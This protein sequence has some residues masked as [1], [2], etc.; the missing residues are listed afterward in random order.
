MSCDI[1]SQNPEDNNQPT[2]HFDYVNGFTYVNTYKWGQHS[3]K[4]YVSNNA[5]Y[6]IDLQMNGRIKIGPLKFNDVV[7]TSQLVILRHYC[8]I[9]RECSRLWYDLYCRIYKSDSVTLSLPLFTRLHDENYRHIISQHTGPIPDYYFINTLSF[10]TR[11]EIWI[12]IDGNMIV[13]ID[14]MC[15]K[16]IDDKIGCKPHIVKFHSE[17]EE[18][19]EMLLLLNKYV[20]SSRHA[21]VKKM[22]TDIRYHVN[23]YWITQI[24]EILKSLSILLSVLNNVVVSYL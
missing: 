18:I 23:S 13:D 21:P 15:L 14:F 20:E 5:E 12:H 2:N 8:C 10:T 16:F 3:A 4:L 17:R 11:D 1:Y 19:S 6:K 24:R 7:P 22:W 9:H